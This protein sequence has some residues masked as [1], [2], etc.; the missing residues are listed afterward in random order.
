[1]PAPVSTVLLVLAALLCL[2][3]TPW[4]GIPVGVVALLNEFA[5][6]LILL[7]SDSSTPAAPSFDEYE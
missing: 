4:A 5:R 1:M 2:T 7:G 3:V 6:M